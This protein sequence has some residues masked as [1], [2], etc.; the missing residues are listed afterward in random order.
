M[1]IYLVNF[2]DLVPENIGL[3]RDG[4]V[5]SCVRHCLKVLG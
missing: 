2:H 5:D 4:A 1:L 3:I